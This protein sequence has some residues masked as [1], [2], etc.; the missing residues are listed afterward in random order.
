LV[1]GVKPVIF[2]LYDP[3][4]AVASSKILSVIV[5]LTE[6]LQQTPRLVIFE[7]DEDN[8]ALT[9][10]ELYVILLTSIPA[11]FGAGTFP[12]TQLELLPV[13]AKLYKLYN[14]SN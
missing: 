9:V 7:K 8:V 4:V 3:E 2:K 11:I 5:G 10:A 12:K 6:I 14:T 1:S 13:I